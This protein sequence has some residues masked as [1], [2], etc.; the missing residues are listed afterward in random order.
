VLKWRREAIRAGQRKE[1]PKDASYMAG[2]KQ[3]ANPFA[4]TP[5]GGKI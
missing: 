5:L 3:L 1:V 4:P 2:Q